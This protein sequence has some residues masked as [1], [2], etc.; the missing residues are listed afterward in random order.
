MYKAEYITAASTARLV[1]AALKKAFP[2]QKFYVITEHGSSINIYWM[3]GPTDKEVSGVAKAY[4][5]K[6][7]DHWLMPNGTVEIARYW[8][9]YGK[10]FDNR[11][12]PP[13]PEARLVGFM[14]NY[15]FTKK[16][17]SPAHVERLGQFIAAETGWDI[18]T[19]NTIDWWVNGKKKPLQEAHFNVDFTQLVPGS[20]TQPL[21][22][23]YNRRLRES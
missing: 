22:D 13:C 4:A 11:D 21:A 19:I 7:A 23:Y 9:D 14:A 2:G 12:K 1:R 5:G 3:D 6:N 15:V 17:Y 18:P 20:P 10:N 8:G 16:A